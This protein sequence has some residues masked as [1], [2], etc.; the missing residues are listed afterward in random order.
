MS[1]DVSS[2]LSRRLAHCELRTLLVV[3]LLRMLM[4]YERCTAIVVDLC[5]VISPHLCKGTFSLLKCFVP[6]AA[7]LCCFTVYKRQSGLKFDES[8]LLVTCLERRVSYRNAVR[9]D[10][11]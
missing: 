10:E 9:L 7:F 5:L 11:I 2:K 4:E 3:Y 1:R 8:L 6:T